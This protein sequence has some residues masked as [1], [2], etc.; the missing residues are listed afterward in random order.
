MSKIKALAAQ[1]KGAPLEP[2]EFELPE[3]GAEEVEIAVEY[4]GICHSDLSMWNNEWGMTQYP[5]VP[6]H[7]VIGRVTAVGAAAKK[8]KVGDRV[9]L[10]WISASCMECKE[11]LSGHQNICPNQEGTIVGRY[12]G[13][14]EKTRA[15][16]AWA[17]ALPEALDASKFG[18]MFCG[19]ITVFQPIVMSDVKPTD[20][21]AVIGIGG[22]GHMALQFL[23]SW[24]C[25]VTAFTS[26]D[27]KI[28]EAKKL[29]AHKTL[30]SRDP[31]AIKS[32]A[33]TFDFILST[34]NVSLDWDDILAAL[35]PQG[36]F[37]IV[38]ATLEPIPVGAF[39]L[40][41]GEKSI[42]ASPT[43]PPQTTATMLDFCARH[44]IAPIIEEFP[45]SQA[46]EALKHLEDGKAR[47]RI[48][49][50]QDL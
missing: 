27:S 34:V 36:R 11:C 3:L 8:H 5:F 23:H 40:I 29:G 41:P 30:N 33:G 37:H 17:I 18:P 22:L 35:A 15:H 38:G 13:F 49:L 10:G 46:N 1:S 42:A 50:K 6:G 24:G 26:S 44:D 31:E 7:E 16:W 25:E 12:G 28:E 14:A 19:G 4:C 43:G 9:G 48:V 45:M 47:Y 20:K 39:S 21:V 2:F 32:V